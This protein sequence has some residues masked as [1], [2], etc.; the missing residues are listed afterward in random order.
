MKEKVKFIDGLKQDETMGIWSFIR[1]THHGQRNRGQSD[2]ISVGQDCNCK[3][4]LVDLGCNRFCSN[5]C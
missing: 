3:R 5:V 2:A 1:I 4:S